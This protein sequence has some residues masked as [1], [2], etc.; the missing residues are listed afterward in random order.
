[1][2]KL[3]KWALAA[4]FLLGSGLCLLQSESRAQTSQ[5]KP[6]RAAASSKSPAQEAAP[7]ASPGAIFPSVVARVDGEAIY[8]KDLETLVRRELSL[9]G[10]PE[11]KAL[12]GDYRA[13]LA[14]EKMTNLINNKLLY[15]HAKASGIVVPDSEVQAE[16][17]K[18]TKSF[19]SEV[20]MREALKSQFTDMA[21][22]QKGTRESLTVSKFLDGTIRKTIKV[23]A[24]EIAKFYAEHTSDFRHP[25]LVRTSQ[26]FIRPEGTSA[27]QDA[28]A[29]ERAEA[30]LARIQ[31]GEDFEA[32]A[33]DHSMS[34]SASRGGDLG[35]YSREALAPE[36][37]E[38]AFSQPPG[39]VQ[40]A[41]TQMGY[42]IIK[43]GEM[44]KEGLSSL[45]EVKPELAKFLEEQKYQSALDALVQ[46]LRQKSKVEILIAASALLNP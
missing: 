28:S 45:E 5:P 38:V 34:D 39:S 23:S 24:E 22:I 29:R 33:R 30:L 41:R 44:K 13:Q 7:A 42:H 21:A 9:I 10:D 31:K 36:Y 43:V 17:E 3:S 27:A 32:L 6:K 19:E 20:A 2:I 26:I 8:G 35:F 15:H 37:A 46:Q 14:L 1:M 40:L 25:D 12:R 18:F 11:W 4:I 16:V